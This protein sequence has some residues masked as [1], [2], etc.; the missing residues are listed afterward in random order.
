M[1]SSSGTKLLWVTFNITT[2][3]CRLSNEPQSHNFHCALIMQCTLTLSSD[4]SLLGLVTGFFICAIL[5]TI[6]CLNS[7]SCAPPSGKPAAFSKS[8]CKAQVNCIVN[9]CQSYLDKTPQTDILQRSLTTL[10]QQLLKH[11]AVCHI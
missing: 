6:A 11:W 1:S 8:S 9:Q 3:V 4:I 2:E 7:I 5:S 10:Q